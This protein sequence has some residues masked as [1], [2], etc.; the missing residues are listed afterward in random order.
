VKERLFAVREKRP[1][2]F[3]DEKLLTSWGALMIGAMAE[4]GVALGDLP[5]GGV[6][7]VFDVSAAPYQ[8]FTPLCPWHA[9]RLLS[10]E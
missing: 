9:P 4:A 10:P 5:L 6:A 8:V 3:R 7:V 1:R 2:P